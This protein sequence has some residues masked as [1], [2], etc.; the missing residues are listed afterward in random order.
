MTGVQRRT[1]TECAALKVFFS[2]RRAGFDDIA[3]SKRHADAQ[4]RADAEGRQAATEG[5]F[6]GLF[7][8]TH[9]LL[10]RFRGLGICIWGIWNRL[11]GWIEP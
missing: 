11:C 9:R 4:T 8:L 2:G 7:G 6:D 1:T 3:I 10:N 5:R